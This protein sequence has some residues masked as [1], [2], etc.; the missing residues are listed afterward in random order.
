MEVSGGVHVIPTDVPRGYTAGYPG[1]VPLGALG[2]LQGSGMSRGWECRGFPAGAGAHPA[3][4]AGGGL[5]PPGAAGR[6]DNAGPAPGEL[7]RRGRADA[8]ASPCGAERGGERGQRPLRGPSRLR[9]ARCR[10]SPVTM[11]VRPRSSGR[12]RGRGAPLSP[13]RSSVYSASS[14][15]TASS[16]HPIPPR[17]RSGQPRPGPAPP[18][19]APLPHPRPG[20]TDG[21][22]GQGLRGA[23]GGRAGV[24]RRWEQRQRVSAGSAAHD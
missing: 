23:G 15:P 10:R 9:A 14:T 20:G 8:A 24:V 7:Q 1:S 11:A 16:T 12:Q 3:D 5:S 6:Q 18:R 21:R 19:S 2:V 22:T 13:C 17:R 4:A